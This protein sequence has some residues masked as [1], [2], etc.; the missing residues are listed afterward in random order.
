MFVGP[1]VFVD[2]FVAP[3]GLGTQRLLIFM[4][5]SCQYVDTLLCLFHFHQGVGIASGNQKEGVCRH[6]S[7]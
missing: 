1:E 4:V 2:V 5:V 6:G 7:Y 3:W